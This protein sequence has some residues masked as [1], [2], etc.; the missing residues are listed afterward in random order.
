MLGVSKVKDLVRKCLWQK[1]IEIEKYQRAMEEREGM[2][3]TFEKEKDI[4]L[5]MVRQ[6]RSEVKE[7]K[8]TREE[9]DEEIAQIRI[10]LEVK[11]DAS[12]PSHNLIN[13]RFPKISEIP[14]KN[15]NLKRKAVD[16]NDTMTQMLEIQERK[17][18]KLFP[19]ADDSTAVS[20]L[21]TIQEL[22]DVSD[23]DNDDNVISGA[24]DD[25]SEDEDDKNEDENVDD[26]EEAIG[27]EENSGNVKNQLLFDQIEELMVSA[28][29]L[30]E[31]EKP[32]GKSLSDY[33][34]RILE[35][36]SE[37]E[38]SGD[39][40][41][42]VKGG[43]G[44]AESN[45]ES[46]ESDA[47]NKVDG[48][49]VSVI[50]DDLF[51]RMK[52][53]KLSKANNYESEE[54]VATKSESEVLR[55]KTE[56]A[57]VANLQVLRR[58]GR[59]SSAQSFALPFDETNHQS[60]EEADASQ[61]H[62]V[63]LDKSS[64]YE[65]RGEQVEEIEPRREYPA[66][67]FKGEAEVGKVQCEDCNFSTVHKK[68]LRRHV[69]RVHAGVESIEEPTKNSQALVLYDDSVEN[70]PVA[71]KMRKRTGRGCGECE[72][73]RSDDCDQCKYCM[74]KPRNG[75]ANTQ[76][77]KCVVKRC[78]GSPFDKSIEI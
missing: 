56:L 63:E 42:K 28:K 23:S 13:L 61:S 39:D 55:C 24:E 27:K 74:D 1:S 46:A 60:A 59:D 4:L 20:N 15:A 29:S 49:V 66:E 18:Q 5:E 6:L 35:D 65:A 41:R 25:Y 69:Q 12:V 30:T 48:V 73:C 16:D 9:K 77:Q 45:G 71:K 67:L 78:T 51:N 21:E 50:S 34:Q 75:G 37:S 11:L 33:K 19:Y 64:T 8:L 14:Q 43:E 54:D 47:E 2:I 57:K 31:S 32:K 52:K 62:E 76:R 58:E 3:V 17:M 72:G 68:N 44:D 38:E 70:E 10:D 26:K 7:L 40:E 53:E 36:D 22:I